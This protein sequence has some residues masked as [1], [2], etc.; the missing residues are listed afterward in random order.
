MSD[1]VETTPTPEAEPEEAK[2]LRK[3]LNE[4]H[5]TIRG[6]KDKE[7][8][9][10]FTQIGLEFDKGLGKAIVKEYKGGTSV[11][12][13]TEYAKSEYGYEPKTAPD[14]PL[15]AT[16]AEAQAKLDSV[17]DTAGSVVLKLDEQGAIDKAEAEGDYVTTMALKGAQVEAMFRR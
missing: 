5:A 14:N 13:I 10:S 16:I 8:Q 17:G 15:A 7:L 11:E 1:E 12:E 9:E 4:A 3:Q 6:Y 2:G